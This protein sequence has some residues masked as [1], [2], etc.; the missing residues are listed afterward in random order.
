[1]EEETN[2]VE[3]EDR[4]AALLSNLL[5]SPSLQLLIAN[6]ADLIQQIGLDIIRGILLDILV[7]RNLRDSTETLTRRRITALNLAMTSLFLK[8]LSRSPQFIQQLPYT[9][10][11]ILARKALPKFDRWLAQWVLGLTDKGV[12]NVLRDNKALLDSYR[13][14]YIETCQEVID[15][16]RQIYGELFAQMKLGNEPE[17]SVDWL[18]ITYLLNTIG[19]Q[20]LTIRGSE[21]STFGKLFEKLVLG[22][23]LS[24]LG[25]Q[26]VMPHQPGERVFWLSSQNEKRESDATLLYEVGK[27]VR[28]DI[29]FIGRGNPEISL[30][31]VTRFQQAE[32]LQGV[33]FY[34]ATII[35]VDRIG[36]DSRIVEMA[37]AVQGTIV[38]MSATYWPQQVAILLHETLGLEHELVAMP[39]ERVE[40]YL[41]EQ[42]LSVP[43]ESFVAALPINSLE[44]N[45]EPASPA[46]GLEE[47]VVE[48]DDLDE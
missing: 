29:G 43:I 5:E 4:E 25:F 42:L 10:S 28:F 1:M 20:T 38:Q 11:S 18:F 37:R 36:R 22:S 7:G 19:A 13:D 15:R 6:G 16:H 40:D 44:D 12:Q 14:R 35:I 46:D 8:G 9:A 39:P 23:L 24:I 3:T 30:D 33:P 2:G 48:D 34:M 27:G 32:V 45:D 41:K 26:Q 21:K 17:V 47:R 31:K